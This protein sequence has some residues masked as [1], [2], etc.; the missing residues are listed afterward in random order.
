MNFKNK[1]W[2]SFMSIILLFTLKG[3]VQP[4]Y[5]DYSAFRQTRHCPVYQMDLQNTP[6][7]FEQLWYNK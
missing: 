1:I 2:C 7:T 4:F 5:W 6:Q 3:V